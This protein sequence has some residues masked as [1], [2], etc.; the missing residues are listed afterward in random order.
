[1]RSELDVSLGEKF[2]C[3]NVDLPRDRD[4]CVAFQHFSAFV[5]G[6]HSRPIFIYPGYFYI[7]LYGFR[8]ILIH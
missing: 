3:L 1:M 6:K 4:V 7:R 5:V 2:I 8:T